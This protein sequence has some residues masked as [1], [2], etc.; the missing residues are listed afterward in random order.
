VTWPRNHLSRLGLHNISHP[1]SWR[2]NS[3]S[4][5]LHVKCSHCQ[6]SGSQTSRPRPPIPCCAHRGTHPTFFANSGDEALYYYLPTEHAG[7]DL[8]VEIEGILSRY[9]Q[10]ESAEIVVPELGS[11]SPVELE[12]HFPTDQ[13]RVAPGDVHPV[14]TQKRYPGNPFVSEQEPSQ[15][16]HISTRCR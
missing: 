10:H 15:E 1:W 11:S 5:C 12:T 4:A 14:L 9:I 3:Q 16:D 8:T 2:S 13:W 7:E 6:R